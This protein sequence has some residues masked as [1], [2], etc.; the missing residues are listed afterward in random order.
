VSGLLQH[1]YFVQHGAP[2]RT[3]AAERIRLVRLAFSIPSPM[4]GKAP[5]RCGIGSRLGE[6]KMEACAP[7]QEST[8]C[9]DSL[10]LEGEDNGHIHAHSNRLWTTCWV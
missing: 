4:G 2:A 9:S 8:P 5:Y 7:V 6:G 3:L 1:P 10:V